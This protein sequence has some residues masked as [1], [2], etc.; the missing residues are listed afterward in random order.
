MNV[1]SSTF[2]RTLTTNSPGAITYSSDNTSVATVNSAGL[3]TIVGPGST[4]ITANQVAGGVYSATSANYTV[5]VST[6]APTVSFGSAVTVNVGSSAFT[7]TLTT[8]SAGAIS[9]SSSNTGV[10]TVNAS[11]LVTIIS[12]GVATITANQ[13]AN[14]NYSATSANYSVNVST[15]APT[16]SF[17]STVTGHVGDAAFTRTLTTNSAGMV[18]YTSSNTS[19]ATVSL[20]TGQVTILGAG[21]AV[22]TASQVA[23]GNYSATS[24][25][26]TVNASVAIIAPTVSFGSGVSAT[27]GDAPFTQTLTTNSS[28]AITYSSNNTSV[29]TVNASGLVTIVGAGVATITANQVANGPYAAASA[30]Y[31]VNVSVALITPTVSFGSAVTANVGDAAFTRTLTTNSPGAVTYSSDNTS[32]ATVNASGLVTIVGAGAA[33]ITA[34]QAASGGYSATSANYTVNVNAVAPALTTIS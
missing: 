28:G 15:I 6:I 30:N 3:V 26:Y 13:V 7:R 29:A 18:T 32:V 8:N 12:A 5:N 4:T 22:I 10:A 31:S 9:Y 33:N 11:G 14:G 27:V 24:A 17:G 16:V 25:N 20:T 2:T 34:N 23:N 21:S 19:V 1:G